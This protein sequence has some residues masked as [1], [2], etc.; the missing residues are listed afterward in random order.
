MSPGYVYSHQG[1]GIGRG[2]R[3]GGLAPGR[4][5]PFAPHANAHAQRR[6]PIAPGRDFGVRQRFSVG[7]NENGGPVIVAGPGEKFEV[8]L[9]ADGNLNISVTTEPAEPSGNAGNVSGKTGRAQLA[10]HFA[11]AA[12]RMTV[13]ANPNGSVTI[14]PDPGHELITVGDPEYGEVEV[15]ELPVQEP[16]D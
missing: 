5:T 6:A 4:N 8:G 9:D 14:T 3:S 7:L 15:T 11:R 13:A 16:A 2:F 10:R 12:Q 1:G